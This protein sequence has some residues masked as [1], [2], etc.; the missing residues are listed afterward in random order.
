MRPDKRKNEEVREVEIT[1]NFTKNASGSVLITMGE[2]KVIC[3]ASVEEKVPPFLRGQGQ[4]WLTAEYGMLPGA[5]NERVSRDRYKVGGRTMEIQRLIG[6]ALRAAIDL[7]KLGE[8][9][10]TLD[11]DVI[12]ADGGTRTASITGAF[13]ALR[14]AVNKLLAEG[15]VSVDPIIDSVAAVSVG[16]V[17]GELR[18][19]LMYLED[20]AAEVDMNVIMTG[21][22]QLVE[23]QGT[24]EHGTFTRAQLN[25]LLDLA[26]QGAADLVKV[27]KRVLA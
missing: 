25:Q 18:L 21:S 7:Q 5:T 6:R 10:I 3:T 8:R 14:L 4:G 15:K 19:D 20:S 23:V 9:T 17:E 26:A 16:I 13:V 27:Q 11:C 2:T 22:G 1:P 24:G 12:Q